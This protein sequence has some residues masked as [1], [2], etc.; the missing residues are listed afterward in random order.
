MEEKTLF[1]FLLT[2]TSVIK[3]GGKWQGLQVNLVHCI[4]VVVE[5][6]CFSTLPGT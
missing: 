4:C 5:V 3:P 1:S 6:C 2:Q